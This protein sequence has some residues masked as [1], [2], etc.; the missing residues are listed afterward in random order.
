MYS[1]LPEQTAGVGTRNLHVCEL[2]GILGVINVLLHNLECFEVYKCC[3]RIV[4]TT[5]VSK[6]R[7][8]S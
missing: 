3:F 8:A 2:Q 4:L 7:L 5:V 1:F 6:T